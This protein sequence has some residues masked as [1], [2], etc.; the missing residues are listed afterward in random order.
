MASPGREPAQGGEFIPFCLDPQA[1]MFFMEIRQFL[2][3]YQRDK[4]WEPSSLL[5]LALPLDDMVSRVRD[6]S[7]GPGP[8]PARVRGP[9]PA[10][11]A[12]HS[13]PVWLGEL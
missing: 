8:G 12:K 10:P 6:G 2:E 11:N 13:L 5:R 7:A 3:S 1:L 4:K 9:R